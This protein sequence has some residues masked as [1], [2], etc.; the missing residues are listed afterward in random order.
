M[1]VQSNLS[2]NPFRNRVLPWTVTALVSLISVVLLLYLAQA[3][4]SL[5]AKTLGVPS[6]GA[7]AGDAAVCLSGRSRAR[8]SWRDAN[9][10]KGNDG[11]GLWARGR[12]R[13]GGRE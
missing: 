3:P 1:S 5:N 10:R 8:Q 4:M 6:P 13:A 11:A 12:C 7:V 2:S 9:R